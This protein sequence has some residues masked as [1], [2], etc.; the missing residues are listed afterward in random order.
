MPKLDGPFIGFLGIALVVSFAGGA[1]SSLAKVPNASRDQSLCKAGERIIFQCPIGRRI[2]SVCEIS[3]S[4]TAQYRFGQSGDIEFT[5]PKAGAGLAWARTGY[6]GGG[7]L[8][9]NFRNGAHRYILY[10][11]TIRT[12]FGPGGNDPKSETGVAV[13]RGNKLLSDRRCN[14]PD[15]FAFVGDVEKA[16]PEGEFITW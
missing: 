12:N 4:Q 13:L 14:D 10:S 3:A 15:K 5:Y 9:I 6:S 1:P 11:R 7:E 2:A 8:Q 16:M